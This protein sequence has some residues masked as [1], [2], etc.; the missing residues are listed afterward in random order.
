MINVMVSMIFG[1]TWA[2]MIAWLWFDVLGKK[3]KAWKW[4]WL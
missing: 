2:V 1:K 4:R 3:S